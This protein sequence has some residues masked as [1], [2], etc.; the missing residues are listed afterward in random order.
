MADKEVKTDNEYLKSIARKVGN[1]IVGVHSDN[2]YLKRIEDKISSGGGEPYDDTDIKE[3]MGYADIPSGEN[4]QGQISELQGAV[5]DLDGG[6]DGK[7]DVNHTHTESDITDLGDYIS[8]SNVSGFVLNDGTIDEHTYSQS[9]HTHQMEDITDLTLPEA[10]KVVTDKGTASAD[11]MDKL[12][13]EVSNDS[14]DVYY[15]TKSG[16]TYSWHKMDDDILDNLSI[17]W[18]DIQHKPTIPVVVDTVADG[19]SNAVTS[20]ATYDTFSEMLDELL[21]EGLFLGGDSIVQSGGSAVL[22]ARLYGAIGTSQTIA[23][24]QKNEDSEDTLLGT[25][26]TDSGVAKYVYSA[27]GAGK[28]EIYAKKGSLQTESYSIWDCI[29]YDDISSDTNANYYLN[30]SSGT[31]LAYDSTNQKLTVTCGSNNSQNYVDLRTS[32]SALDLND[33]KGKT[34]RFKVNIINTAQKDLQLRV[35]EGST[36]IASSTDWTTASGE[37]YCD[38]TISSNASVV[39]FRIF[40]KMDTGVWVQSDTYSFKDFEIYPI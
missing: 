17:D 27:I 20:N 38:A 33:L 24:Y 9:G 12:Y 31:S 40:P 22:T 34:V 15:T 10:I 5:E 11:T 29:Y 2:Y 14:A 26:S 3:K 19:N 6:L 16:N 35:Y 37:V 23:F 7:A 30:T 8:K 39:Y 32:N 1:T 21:S 28:K 25:V 18:S 13:I 36:Q 4:L